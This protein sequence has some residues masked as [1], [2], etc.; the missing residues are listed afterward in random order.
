MHKADIAR[1]LLSF[2]GLGTLASTLADQQAIKGAIGSNGYTLLV[3]VGAL[4]TFAST[5]VNTLFSPATSAVPAPPSSLPEQIN[6]KA[7]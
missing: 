3:V 1:L 6:A 2:A 7:P 4:G 5:L